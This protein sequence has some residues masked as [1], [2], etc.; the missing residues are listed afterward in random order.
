MNAVPDNV[1]GQD[2]PEAGLG[3]R[4]LAALLS[5]CERAQTLAAANADP[6][7]VALTVFGQEPIRRGPL[8]VAAMCGQAF[9][10][11]LASGTKI[12]RLV[13]AYRAAQL[14][15]TEETPIA[16]DLDLKEGHT[17]SDVKHAVQ[18]TVETI[19]DAV[20]TRKTVLLVQPS[21]WC[22]VAGHR[23]LIHP[24]GIWVRNGAVTVM[25]IKTYLDREAFTDPVAFTSAVQQTAI[26]VV[27]TEQT[28]AE[29]G[30]D[31]PVESTVH[32][33]FRHQSYSGV[34][35][36][37]VDATP[38]I[39]AVRAQVV[40]SDALADQVD[41]STMDGVRQVTHRYTPLC[42]R[43]CG[44]AV[45]CRP[46]SDEALG[47]NGVHGHPGLSVLDAAG[48]SVAAAVRV[49]SGNDSHPGLERFLRSGWAAA[50]VPTSLPDPQRV[51]PVAV[52][53]PRR[54]G[55]VMSPAERRAAARAKAQP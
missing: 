14:L 15:G 42:D 44:M 50:T 1:D 33:V 47:R 23:H 12:D 48:L 20:R 32:I 6:D 8:A 26:G 18:R 51:V 5:P 4:G 38:E 25:E 46:E 21:V 28:L 31:L 29:S 24:D 11:S 34:S 22:T 40:A 19:L 13:E 49:A 7:H 54:G 27:A 55:K 30:H 10:L 45:V 35:V 43:V 39:V 16:V 17:D 2:R 3:A 41:P 9:E 36:R 52:T 37:E 53:A